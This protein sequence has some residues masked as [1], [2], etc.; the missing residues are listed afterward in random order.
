M[1]KKDIIISSYDIEQRVFTYS[2][3]VGEA[4]R[5]SGGVPIKLAAGLQ[6]SPDDHIQ[7]NDHKNV[8][9]NELT[10]I[11]NKNFCNCKH[12]STNDEIHEGYSIEKFEL[13]PPQYFPKNLIDELQK[14]MTNYLVMR[15]LQQWML[16]HKPDEAAI[17]A[18]ETE[19][20]TIQLREI[21]N[22]RVK[23]MRL[24]RRRKNNIEI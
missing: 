18:S 15:I 8:A 16:Q 5:N 11:I 6:A 17:T 19:K 21:M 22:M 13:F 3:Y 12:S 23:P 4:R 9:V 24:K 20:A 2:Y 14:T 7:I 1:N 10:K